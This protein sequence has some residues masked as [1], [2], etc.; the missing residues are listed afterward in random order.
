MDGGR[1]VHAGFLVGRVGM[2]GGCSWKKRVGE[3]M[4]RN[5]KKKP[6]TRGA[7]RAFLWQAVRIPGS[8]VNLKS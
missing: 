2:V 1:L 4:G 7:G 8:E 5:A 3:M 6:V